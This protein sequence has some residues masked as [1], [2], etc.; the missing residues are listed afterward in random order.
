[1]A[2]SEAAAA[3]CS[4]VTLPSNKINQAIRVDSSMVTAV[5]ILPLKGNNPAPDDIK[6]PMPICIQPSRAAALPAFFAKG[7]IAM[8]AALG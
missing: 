7:A 4:T 2:T 3:G 8:A 6:P 1:M 5:A